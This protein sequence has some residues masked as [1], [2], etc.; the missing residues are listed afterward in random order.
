MTGTLFSR[1]WTGT[2][3]G[4]AAASE[5]DSAKRIRSKMED[6]LTEARIAGEEGLGD[7]VDDMAKSIAG[8]SNRYVM[9]RRGCRL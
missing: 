9:S 6:L 5:T 4:C 7:A 3:G 8:R 1:G 2:I